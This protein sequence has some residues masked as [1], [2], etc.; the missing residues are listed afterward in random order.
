MLSVLLHQK[1][2][3]AIATKARNQYVVIAAKPNLT[4]TL[5]GTEA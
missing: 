4:T 2:T 3:A 1:Q 5:T